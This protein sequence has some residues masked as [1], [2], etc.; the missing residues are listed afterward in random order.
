MWEFE[1]NAIIDTFQGDADVLT[2]LEKVGSLVEGGFGVIGVEYFFYLFFLFL[3]LRTLL[4]GLEL[5][6]NIFL[7]SGDK[8][9]LEIL[10]VI[11]LGMVFG[12]IVGFH[13]LFW[14]IN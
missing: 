3:L 1:V 5:F 13:F 9:R 10:A 14:F 2:A 4:I 12:A 7:H 6:E 11:A 8:E